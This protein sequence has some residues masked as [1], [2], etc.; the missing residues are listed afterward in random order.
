[1]QD[2][3]ADKKAIKKAYYDAMRDCHPDSNE[4]EEA[5]EFATF[6]NDIYEVRYHSYWIWASVGK[7]A[8]NVGS[9]MA[10]KNWVWLLFQKFNKFQS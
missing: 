8:C 9:V 10:A 3:E 5:I 1:M 6:L 7:P 4:G 2:P